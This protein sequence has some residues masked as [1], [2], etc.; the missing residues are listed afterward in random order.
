[1]SAR[2]A[3][4][5]PPTLLPNTDLALERHGELG[6]AWLAGMWQADPLA[7]AVVAAGG[8]EVKAVRRA[9]G[10]DPRS[11]VGRADLPP[12]A[13][14]L[15]ADATAEPDWLERDRLDRAA[16][17][18]VR[19]SAQWGLVLGAASLLRGADNWVAARP[20]LLTGR[21]G[22]QPAVR[23]IEVGEWLSEVVR[24]GG[25]A[26]DGPGFARTL[27]VRLIHAHV[28]RHVREHAEWDDSALG[29][30]I[31]Q[32][33]MAFTLAEF[34][35]ISLDAMARLGVRLRDDELA[36]IYHLWRYVGHVIGV[37]PALNPA[38]E[39]GHVAIED[40]YRL[41]SPGPDDYSRDFVRALTE[42]YL[43]PQLAGLVPGPQAVTR[44]AA[45]W[46]LYGA[47]R[48][49]L[50]DEASDALAIPDGPAK[51]VIRAARPGLFLLDQARL[52][53]L[54]RERATARGYAD[55]DR[56][57]ARLKAENA[58]QHDLVDAVHGAVG[59]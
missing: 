38:D 4:P 48:V 12:R 24:P 26:V 22:H 37:D 51:H 23:S 5:A 43:A 31:P 13:A 34:G 8:A 11:A 41:T 27:R 21:Y 59:H 6:A 47:S 32:P 10:D 55:R 19:Y 50:G 58:M 15:L 9:L 17:A 16:D 14:A 2:S 44:P 42:G 7:D 1:M 57:L 33:Y 46:L 3:V 36:D 53:I 49:F 54:G 39:S 45:T 28:R 30:P 40:L 52:R 56:E 25:M 35:H 29:V 20:L 18:L